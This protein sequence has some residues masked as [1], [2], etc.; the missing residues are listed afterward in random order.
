MQEE[1][2][3]MFRPECLVSRLFT[4]VLDD[5]EALLIKGADRYCRYTGYGSTFQFGG[6][7]R[8]TIGTD[9]QGHRDVV[10]VGIDARHY[11]HPYRQRSAP[12]PNTLANIQLSA[13]MQQFDRREIDRE[14]RK[15]IV[16]FLPGTAF[17]TPRGLATGN[18]GSG[19]FGGMAQLKAIIQLIAASLAFQRLDGNEYRMKYL[20]FQ[21]AALLPVEPLADRSRHPWQVVA[22]RVLS[23]GTTV[24]ELYG[25]LLDYRADVLQPVLNMQQRRDQPQQQ[26]QQQ[27]EARWLDLFSFIMRRCEQPAATVE[28]EDRMDVDLTL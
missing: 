17:Q 28:S 25:W 12:R 26:Q 7:Y 5:N 15:A 16:G 19:A 4:E 20:T 24:G 18:W 11:A 27:A 2:L 6:D 8:E 22:D 3:F 1:I 23:R 9:A 13:L 10:V 21:D 14:I